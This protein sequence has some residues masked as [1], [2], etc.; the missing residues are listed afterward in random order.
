LHI[1]SF[2]GRSYAWSTDQDVQMPCRN[3]GDCKGTGVHLYVYEAFDV[4]RY[5]TITNDQAHAHV[6][7]SWTTRRKHC[8]RVRQT[9]GR[10]ICVDLPIT[11]RALERLFAIVSP[12]VDG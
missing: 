6:L 1:V 3:P 11:F 10:R 5:I 2:Y 9:R 8:N 4:V 7:T 12:L